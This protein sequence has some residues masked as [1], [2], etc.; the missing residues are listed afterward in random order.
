MDTMYD[1]SRNALCFTLETHRLQPRVQVTMKTAS[2]AQDRWLERTR[3]R[4]QMTQSSNDEKH[5]V[6]D[7]L[8]HARRSPSLLGTLQSLCTTPGMADCVR[9]TIFAQDEP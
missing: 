9:E 1:Q 2:L 3:E 6:W 4:L 8:R 5:L 7:A